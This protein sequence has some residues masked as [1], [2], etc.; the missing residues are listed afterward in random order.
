MGQIMRVVALKV[1]RRKVMEKKEKLG[2]TTASGGH[3]L[4]WNDK[5]YGVEFHRKYLTAVYVT[6]YAIIVRWKNV[7]IV[8]A[9]TYMMCSEK[10]I[11][12]II[13]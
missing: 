2:D 9:V 10:F 12:N 5:L 8:Q 11:M 1:K 3:L 6:T 7:L 13:I 4:Y